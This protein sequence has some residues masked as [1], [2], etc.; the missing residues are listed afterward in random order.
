MDIHSML[1]SIPSFLQYNSLGYMRGAFVGMAIGATFGK[2]KDCRGATTRLGR[3][4]LLEWA[5]NPAVA[6]LTGEGLIEEISDDPGAIFGLAVG[7]LAG[8]Y[9]REGLNYLWDAYHGR[10]Q[11]AQAEPPERYPEIVIGRVTPLVYHARRPK[12]LR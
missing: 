12:T 1:D 2:S 6:L 4:T 5:C 7:R 8:E 3:A 10:K 9:I 11:P